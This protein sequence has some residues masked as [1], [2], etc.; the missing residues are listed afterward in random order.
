MIAVIAIVLLAAPVLA[1]ILGFHLLGTTGAVVGVLAGL[2]LALAAVVLP[3][4]L[5][6]RAEKRK[7]RAP[8]P[9]PPDVPW[10]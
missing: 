4:G 9:P 10:A 8:A 3:F 2:L 6:V 1:G 5:L 7:A